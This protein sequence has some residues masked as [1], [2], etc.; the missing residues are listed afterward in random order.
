MSRNFFLSF[1]LWLLFSLLI[2]LTHNSKAQI[3]Y[4]V[5]V[6]QKWWED[7]SLIYYLRDT[8]IKVYKF[9]ELFSGD[10]QLARFA[11]PVDGRPE[12][13]KFIAG[14]SFDIRNCVFEQSDEPL[15]VNETGDRVWNAGMYLKTLD[16]DEC[17]Y[18]TLLYFTN[19]A[20]QDARLEY[21]DFSDIFMGDVQSSVMEI[22]FSNLAKFE[23]NK[24]NYDSLYFS[25]PI[26]SKDKLDVI[27]KNSRIDDVFSF[28]NDS[29]LIT[30]LSFNGD[31]LSGSCSIFNDDSIARRKDLRSYLL[32]SFTGKTLFNC[33][34]TTANLPPKSKLLFKNCYFGQLAELKDIGFDTIIF[35]RCIVDYP[36]YM[37]FDSIDK[38]IYL[39]F[40]NTNTANIKFD[41][42][43]RVNLFFDSTTYMDIITSSY[44]NLLAKFK[45]EG[46]SES[47]K[48]TDI[49]YQQYSES[50]FVNFLNGWWWNYGYSKG[51]ILGW[52]LFFLIFFHI[53]NFFNWKRMQNGYSMVPAGDQFIRSGEAGWRYFL[54]RQITVF[55]YTC[56]IFFSLKID[57]GKL[58]YK[59][60]RTLFL[61]FIQY[62]IGLTCLFFIANA[63]LKLG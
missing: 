56:Y 44:E 49:A 13:W 29:S 51:Y 41:F 37:S 10:K 8:T 28:S 34:L 30:V 24:C 38:P 5:S 63:I 48:N 6:K 20:F 15:P 2:V 42:T 46:R 33:A 11:R 9:Q 25:H 1:K 39:S 22:G 43:E 36:L 61:F 54:R 53:I 31:T 16:I 35:D 62:I 32:A 26:A 21:N 58:R 55:I 23:A 7:E 19:I 57:F 40:I 50:A 12:E 17:T 4:K 47:Y 14:V 27:L 18:K 60:G 59:S 45:E 52:T 3:R